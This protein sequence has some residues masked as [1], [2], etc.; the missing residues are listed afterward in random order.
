M[1]IPASVMKIP[2]RRSNAKYELIFKAAE[3]PGLG[4]KSFYVKA[5]KT[6]APEQTSVG[7]TEV[8]NL[9]LDSGKIAV[10]TDEGGALSGVRPFGSDAF[11]D[12]KQSY[13]FYKGHDGDNQN[14]NRASGAYAFR[15]TDDQA[16]TP[17]KSDVSAMYL[18]GP[19]VQELHQVGGDFTSFIE[20]LVE[21]FF[22]SNIANRICQ[23]NHSRVQR[24]RGR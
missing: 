24:Q 18:N 21:L 3:I 15:P 4:F 1:P 23:P 7:T 14:G 11:M 5:N 10:S 16:R 8:A 12:V 17:L 6:V 19:L 20:R 9:V 2:G 13:A 22:V